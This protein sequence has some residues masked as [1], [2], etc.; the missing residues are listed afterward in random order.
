MK[1]T[2]SSF[3]QS[4]TK[5]VGDRGDPM[6]CGSMETMEGSVGYGEY[7]ITSRT[8]PRNGKDRVWSARRYLPSPT[9]VPVKNGYFLLPHR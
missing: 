9:T 3:S 4:H 5:R 8:T 1:N 6:I 2:L 7:L